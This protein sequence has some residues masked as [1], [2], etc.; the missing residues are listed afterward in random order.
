[1]VAESAAVVA[2]IM[3]ARYYAEPS[4]LLRNHPFGAANDQR[5]AN[6]GLCR[7]RPVGALSA[8]GHGG[9]ANRAGSATSP[10]RCPGCPDH[11]PPPVWRAAAAG[12]AA[13]HS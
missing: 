5:P 1:M 13:M 12:I 9:A 6:S 8:V 7:S 4:H 10:H 11:V 2:P 3:P